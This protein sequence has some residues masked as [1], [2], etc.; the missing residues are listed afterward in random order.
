MLA[1]FATD[2]GI[3]YEP[4]AKP[5]CVY[6]PVG[7][8]L[9]VNQVY[10]GCIITFSERRSIANLI[11]L[12]MVNFDVILGMDWLS[13]YHAILD[14]HAK[15]MTLPCLGLPQLVWTAASSSYPNRVIYYM[16][17]CRLI[18][19]GCLTYLAHVWACSQEPPSLETIRVVSEFMDV[20]L[21][22]LP[23]VP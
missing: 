16:H 2:L 10:R 15:T 9:V 8:S 1:Y 4:L 14:C 12:Y 6:T 20:F 11:L 19:K 3:M 21:T 17:D 5:I 22:D 18:D 7:E 23:G 13:S